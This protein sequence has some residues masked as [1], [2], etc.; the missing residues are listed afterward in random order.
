M[1]RNASGLY[2]QALSLK[3]KLL[4]SSTCGKSI[5]Y[6]SNWYSGL[7][8]VEVMARLIYGEANNTEAQIKGVA[9]VLAN[10]KEA[11]FA[12]SYYGVSTQKSQFEAIVG[13]SKNTET[14]R[15]PSI[16]CSRWDKATELACILYVSNTKATFS[17]ITGRPTGYVDQL[18]F[19]GKSYFDSKTRNVTSYSGGTG[20]YYINSAWKAIKNINYLGDPSGN[21]FFDYK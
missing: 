19:L 4:G 13:G 3:S 2:N 15:N 18:Y 16:A 21:V 7:S 5:S 12:S 8:E 17:T 1:P 9:W 10:R 14:A 20:E 11:G 6:S